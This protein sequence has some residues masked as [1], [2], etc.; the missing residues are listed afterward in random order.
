MSKYLKRMNNSIKQKS[1]MSK[2]DIRAP[3]KNV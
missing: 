3:S 2:K 1:M